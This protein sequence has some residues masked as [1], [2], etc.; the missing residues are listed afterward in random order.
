MPSASVSSLALNAG[1]GTALMVSAFHATR[2][3]ILSTEA[4][5]TPPPT[6]QQSLTLAAKP[7]TIPPASSVPADGFSTLRMS[8]F[9]SMIYAALTTK[10]ESALPATMATPWSTAAANTSPIMSLT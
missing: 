3:M 1:L 6:P 5:S 8:A 4:A 7:G 9:L 2:A 10:T